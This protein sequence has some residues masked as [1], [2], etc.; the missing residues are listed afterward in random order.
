M[1]KA[2]MSSMTVVMECATKRILHISHQ[3]NIV[4]ERLG[5]IFRLKDEYQ[6]PT[7]YLGSTGGKMP[8]EGTEA[9]L[10]I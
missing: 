5:S 4:M 9:C 3:P 1:D 7:R 10:E 8:I 2:V 6:N